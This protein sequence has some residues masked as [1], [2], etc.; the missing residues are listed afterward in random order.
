M[1][2]AREVFWVVSSIF[3]AQDLQIELEVLKCKQEDMKALLILDNVC[4]NKLITEVN[5]PRPR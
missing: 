4:S 1:G 5:K 2:N 3:Y